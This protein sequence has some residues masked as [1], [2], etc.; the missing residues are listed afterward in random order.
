MDIE[1]LNTESLFKDV[2]VLKVYFGDPIQI[3]D[4]IVL[5]QP[6]IG[7]IVEYGEVEFWYL[8]NQLCSNPTSMRLSLWDAGIDWTKMKDF[9]LFISIISAIDKDKSKLIFGD[10]DLQQFKPVLVKDKDNEEDEGKPVLIYLP[11]PIIQID[12]AKYER[13]VGYLRTM[14]NIHPK[15]E[16]AKDKLTKQWLIDEERT[17]IINEAKFKKNTE[18]KPSVL[19]S[20]ISAALNHP[21]FKYK[22]S[23]L[24]DVHI[25]EF[26]DSIRRLQIYENTTALL[27]GMYSGMIDAKSIKQEELNWV[28]DIYL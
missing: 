20:M 8:A 13:I 10:L 9:D 21:G 16:K 26:M 22:K 1:E 2:D 15:V 28:R 5:Y 23:E 17:K 11:N 18:W 27:K 6:T 4:D 7:D 19:F 12:E 24:K 3:D 14:F 25:F